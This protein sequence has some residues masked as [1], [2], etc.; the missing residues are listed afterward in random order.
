MKVIK[1][2][3]DILNYIQRLEYELSG[4][5]VLIKEFTENVPEEVELN[6]DEEKYNLIIK[7]YQQIDIERKLVYSSLVNESYTNLTIDFISGELRYE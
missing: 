4:Y 7:K 1:V 3:E 5:E 2:P 6:L